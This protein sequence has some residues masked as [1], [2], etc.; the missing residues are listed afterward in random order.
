MDKKVKIEVTEKCAQ[1]LKNLNDSSTEDM[2]IRL[3]TITEG[4]SCL[5][6]M[7]QVARDEDVLPEFADRI[8]HTMNCLNEYYFLVKSLTY[9]PYDNEKCM[10]VLK[11]ERDMYEE[12]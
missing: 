9:D 4:F 12:T 2:D 1:V 6:E 8:I 10:Y 3:M 7:L 11:D 5:A